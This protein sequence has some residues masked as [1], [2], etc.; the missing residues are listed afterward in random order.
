MA[1][2]PVESRATVRGRYRSQVQDE[3]KRTALDQLATGGPG[4][5]SVNAI[6]RRLGVSGPALYRYFPSRDALLTA[7]TLDAYADFGT[8]L[9]AATAPDRTPDPAGRLRALVTAYREWA[10]AHPHRYALLYRVAVPGYDA[11][12]AELVAAARPLMDLTLEILDGLGPPK[13]DDGL[14]R[15]QRGVALWSRCHGLV[16]LELNGNFAS[17]SVDPEALYAAEVARLLD[18]ASA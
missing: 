7:L 13:G 11:H 1:S 4:S 5:V 17:M 6:G 18:G 3:V 2:T 8:A 10:R 15:E 12:A 14:S 9:R 16:D